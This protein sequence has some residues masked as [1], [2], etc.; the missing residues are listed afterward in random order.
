MYIL[1]NMFLAMYKNIDIFDLDGTLLFT[2]DFYHGK[3]IW[4][5]SKGVVWSYNGWA[6]KAESLDLDVFHIP[7][8]RYVYSEYLKSRKDPSSLTVMATGRLLKLEK[9]V[10]AIL[11]YH[12]LEF[13]LKFLN[14]NK[15]TYRF[16]TNLFSDLINKYDP[17][18]FTIYD[19][20]HQHLVSFEKEWAP[21]QKCRI[22]IIDV[23]KSD[24]TRKIVGV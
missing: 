15:E 19:D 16:K 11:D 23:T 22:E 20:R 7:L 21:N 18:V 8:N 3:E 4:E 9:A 2:P 10:D 12:G 17:S 13:D 1:R 14:P 5:K 6:S 24:K